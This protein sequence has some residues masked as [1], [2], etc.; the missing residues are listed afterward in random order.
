MLR[1]PR[2]CCEPGCGQPNVRGS[3]W[4]AKHQLDNSFFKSRR[5]F[6]KQR[7]QKDEVYRQYGGA[8]WR[9]FRELMLAQN[10]MCQ[11][12]QKDG[13]HCRYPAKIVHHLISPRERRDLFL[14][15]SNVACVCEFDHPN[16]EGTPH[17]RP[18]IDYFATVFAMP[19]VG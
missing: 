15:P 17:W 4:C 6:N 19:H 8:L 16:T 10:P 11:K 9:Q 1:C 12:I 18:G 5:E 2:V 3:R 14:E 7:W 13:G